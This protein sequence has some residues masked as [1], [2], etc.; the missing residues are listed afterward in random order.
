MPNAERRIGSGERQNNDT[1]QKVAQSQIDDEII[2][3]STL[4]NVFVDD[5]G[6]NNEDIAQD[7]PDGDGEEKQ[8]EK[9]WRQC[10]HHRRTRRRKDDLFADQF[11]RC[12]Q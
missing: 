9:K 8:T 12:T 4:P 1:Q 11:A 3:Q 2:G 7:R 6:E 10:Q 5:E